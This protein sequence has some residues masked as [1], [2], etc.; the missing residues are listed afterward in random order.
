M[1]PPARSNLILRKRRRPALSCVQCRQRKVRCDR[2]FPCGPCVRSR[3]SLELACF[4]EDSKRHSQSAST[5]NVSHSLRPEH[6][7]PR[8]ETSIS[9]PS[10]DGESERAAASQGQRSIEDL[11]Q[12]IFQLEETVAR[13]VN[14]RGNFAQA[15]IPN[16]GHHH[17]NT[18]RS[19]GLQPLK[20]PAPRL[21]SSID[22]TKVFSASHWV[23]IAELV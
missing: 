17:P 2:G 21:R 6:L 4:Y 22:K 1:E 19:V 20:A 3:T 11:Q 16:E 15:S 12:R 14:S 18:D 23:H 8:Q 10:N 9:L 13:S 7:V 5:E